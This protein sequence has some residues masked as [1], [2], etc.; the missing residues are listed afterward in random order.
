MDATVGASARQLLEAGGG[1]GNSSTG[2]MGLQP[3]RLLPGRRP[4]HSD[5]EAG[6]GTSSP[7]VAA[8][9]LLQEQ[10]YH[11]HSLKDHSWRPSSQQQQQQHDSADEEMGRVG[12]ASSSSSV[13]GAKGSMRPST[14]LSPPSPDTVRRNGRLALL[15]MLLLVFQG[16]ALSIMLRY[17]RARAGQAYL[18]SV[19]VILTEVIKLA[20][21]LVMQLRVIQADVAA[22][23]S[24]TPGGPAAP[25]GPHAALAAEVRRQAADILAQSLPMLLPAAMFVMQ[26]VLLI[27]AATHL[28]AV[29]FQIFSQSFKLVPTALF[30]YWLLGQMLE[31]VQWASI[32]VLAAG[33]ILVTVNNG[34]GASSAH[35]SAAAVA[36]SSSSS[37][38]DYVTGMVACSISGLSSAYAGVYFE[39]YVKGR[40]AASLWVRNIQLGIFGV[41]LSTGYALLKDGWRMRTGGVLQGF[42]AATWAVIAL[43]VFGGLVTGMVVKYCDNILKNFA[44][45]IS[46]ILTVLVAIPLFGQWPSPVFLAGVALVLLSVFMYGRALDTRKLHL[47]AQRTLKRLFPQDGAGRR[48]RLLTLLLLASAAAG[49]VLLLSGINSS[50][51]L[52]SGQALMGGGRGAKLSATDLQQEMAAI[53]GSEKLQGGLRKQVGQMLKES[54]GQ[55]QLIADGGRKQHRLQQR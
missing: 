33:V 3:L 49:F 21:C 27:V 51:R 12:V 41:P 53:E 22:G 35:L 30:A 14:P 20:I 15:S 24:S 4:A 19:S 26:Q 1:S 9:Q 48:R 8:Q 39:K 45:A 36:V 52:G 50:S 47:M 2:N 7:V 23:N 31:P 40:H 32:P 18:A 54:A 5:S 16:T 13:N 6:L 10:L 17:S 43:Q 46:V 34:G 11:P 25:A 38:L 28:D 37:G 29:A 44:L 42:D 55:Q